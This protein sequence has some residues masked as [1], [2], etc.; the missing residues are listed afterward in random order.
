MTQ[1]DSH[2]DD[3]GVPNAAANDSDLWRG[4]VWALLTVATVSLGGFVFWV[5][6]AATSPNDQQVGIATAWYT[7]LQL[8][9]SF[10]ALGL[11]ILIT[12]RG[13][14]PNISRIT[15]SALGVS[16]IAALAIGSVAPTF[17]ADNW[18]SLSGSS[19]L[20][21][22]P[23]L[24]LGTLGTG[25]ALGVDARLMSLRRWRAVFLRGTIPVAIRIPLL[26][27]DPLDDRATWLVVLMIAPLALSGFFS[28]LWLVM[29]K[30]IEPGRPSRLSN[31][32]RTYFA[33]QHL[34]SLATQ[35]PYFLVPFLVSR[36][37]TG[38]VNAAFYLVWGIGLMV[39]IVPQTLAQVLLSETSLAATNRS[40]RVRATLGANVLLVVVA[41]AASLVLARPVL[42]YIG[43]TY[44]DLAPILPWLLLAALAWGVTSICL[45]EARL[46]NDARTTNLITWSLAL[47]TIVGC[48]TVLPSR[49]IWGSTVVW[50]CANMTTMAIA[51]IALDRRRQAPAAPADSDLDGPSRFSA[52]LTNKSGRPEN[53]PSQSPRRFSESGSANG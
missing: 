47:G 8:G 44:A 3:P 20:T 46:A 13:S 30:E 37:V 19:G 12:R 49:P 42:E 52:S 33:S 38:E 10:S 53:K 1:L 14:A 40:R 36:H 4:S 35:A 29:T 25:L 34:A 41:W 16:A 31:Q 48:V 28:C 18:S 22:A 26:F 45:T 11:P 2:S 17:A 15:G 7:V 51:I 5:L 39:A 43:P 50:L 6:A 9:V 21:L 32:D 23:F 27:V 24:A